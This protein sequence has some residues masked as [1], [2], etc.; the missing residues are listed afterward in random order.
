M[1]GIWTRKL[2]FRQVYNLILQLPNDS[3]LKKELAGP[4]ALWSQSEHMIASVIDELRVL[5]YI[6]FVAN[7]GKDIKYPEP[8][9]RPGTPEDEKENPKDDLTKKFGTAEEQAQKVF[10]MLSSMMN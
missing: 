3:A 8:I 1:R 9:R 7:G 10:G 5:K 4:V 2:T 6:T